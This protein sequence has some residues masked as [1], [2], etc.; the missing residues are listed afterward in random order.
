MI[1]DD[2]SLADLN[3]LNLLGEDVYEK[4]YILVWMNENT[5]RWYLKGEK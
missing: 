3:K 1:I 2:Y 5:G 4:L